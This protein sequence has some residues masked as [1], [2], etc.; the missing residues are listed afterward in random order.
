[1]NSYKGVFGST[2]GRTEA[3]MLTGGQLEA[4]SGITRL[5]WGMGVWNE[6]VWALL[7]L[8]F[9]EYE[10]PPL[11]PAIATDL[12]PELWA[13]ERHMISNEP[14]AFV[15]K[16]TYRTA[17]Y[18]LCSAQ[19]HCPGERGDREHV[20]QATLGPDAVAF[21]NHP[22][23]MS[24]DDARRPN[25]WRG[26]GVLPRVAQWKDVLVA[27]HHL[28]DDGRPDNLGFTHAYF[29]TYEFDE[30]TFEENARGIRWAFARQG[31]GYLA[32][33][34]AQGFELLR[35][36]LTAYRELRSYG[37]QNVW[38][39]MMGREAT[40][41]SFAQ[42]REAALALDIELQALRLSCET[43]RGQRL[44]FG[45]EGPLLVNG[46]EQPLSGY[47]HYD[48]RYCVAEMGATEMDIQY[49]DYT[50]RLGFE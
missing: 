27:I 11:I 46:D 7:G 28:P 13:R 21:V 34:A 44:S 39:C 50:M 14:L 49:G 43:L 41:G 4:T 9:S 36:G 24:H 1:V 29:P 16:A 22:A 42:F 47:K 19:D 35:R 10:P 15:N 6:H 18:M 5:M 40:D 20:W 25:F 12:E 3:S 32:L 17:D 45:W 30:Y 48:S 31:S 8:A 37:R 23:C 33:A 26:N 38:L 2:H